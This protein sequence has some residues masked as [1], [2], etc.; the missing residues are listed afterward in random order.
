M[1]QSN[2]E[3]WASILA[4]IPDVERWN[5]NLSEFKRLTEQYGPECREFIKAEADRRGYLWHGASHSYVC[6]WSMHPCEGRNA[7]GILGAG[8][9]EGQLAVIFAG[10]DGPVRYESEC[11]DVPRET[12]DKLIHGLY[13]RKL[14]Q[15]LVLNKGIKMV[16]VGP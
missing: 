5:A 13:P 16:K 14:Y 7:Q 10:K 12:V 6:P 3:V 2:T 4:A 8:W 15:Q 11:R 9:R 1:S